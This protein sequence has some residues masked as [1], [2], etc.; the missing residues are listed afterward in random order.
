[1]KASGRGRAARG[2]GCENL[3]LDTKRRLESHAENRHIVFRPGD[4]RVTL[5]DDFVRARRRRS[6]AP[7]RSLLFVGTSAR[8]RDASARRRRPGRASVPPRRPTQLAVAGARVLL[9]AAVLA[10]FACAFAALASHDSWS[11]P[12][13]IAGALARVTPPASSP[14]LVTPEEL[15]TRD[16]SDDSD[17]RVWLA[18]L[19]VVY[20]VT[21]GA[22]HYAPGGAYAG[23]AARDASAAF[24]TGDFTPDGLHPSL[25]A[26]EPDDFEAAV[27]TL[28]EWSKFYEDRY[29]RVGVLAP[30]WYRDASG[31][32]TEMTL[33]VAEARARRPARAARGGRRARP[34][35]RRAARGGRRPRA[36]CGARTGGVT[37]GRCASSRGAEGEVRPLSGP[38]FLGRQAALPRVRDA[39]P[40]CKT[41]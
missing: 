38:G 35:S 6:A 27:A 32:R 26:L 8:S 17:P 29:E 3:N 12:G 34:P 28:D 23:L 30:G 20:D 15:A 36:G 21:A 31:A 5:L 2:L 24:H 18:I 9:G 40:R 37:L 19:G 7:P 14:R 22:T 16:G 41:G 4:V 10:A 11:L 1:M 25:D 33:R 39:A 13:A